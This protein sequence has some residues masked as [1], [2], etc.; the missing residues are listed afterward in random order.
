MGL[1]TDR[2]EPSVGN[3]DLICAICRG[4]FYNPVELPACRHVFCLDCIRTWSAGQRQ[5]PID[6]RHID[7]PEAFPPAPRIYKSL[8]GKLRLRCEFR[9]EGCTELLTVDNFEKHEKSCDFNP[10]ALVECSK[11]CGQMLKKIHAN[12]HNCV[13]FL[14]STIVEN[15]AL[16]R[17]MQKQIDHLRRCVLS[18]PPNNCTSPLEDQDRVIRQWAEALPRATVNY[19]GGLI[20]TPD[21]GLQSYAKEA[22]EKAH[23]PPSLLASL[24]EFSHERNWPPGLRTLERRLRSRLDYNQYVVRRVPH[25]Q[26]VVILAYE[27][28]HMMDDMIGRP[29]ILIMFAN[30]V[31]NDE[32]YPQF[33]P[34]ISIMDS[35]FDP[36]RYAS[37][38]ASGRLQ[39][40]AQTVSSLSEEGPESSQN[41]FAR[42]MNVE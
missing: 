33:F 40:N 5:C 23:C 27:N 12:D 41:V 42:I 17:S 34:R 19:W 7:T 24:I 11:E 13:K 10:E 26:A 15:N 6:R 25:S 36:N 38:S 3:D 18:S 4:V 29:G 22:L 16:I 31:E 2:F 37:A 1:D 35:E 28:H 21:A 14:R 32:R 30:G 39:A 8:L 20:S 9:E